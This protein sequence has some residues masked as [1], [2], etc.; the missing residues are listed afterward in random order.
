MAADEE[1][2]GR[3]V[4]CISCTPFAQKGSLPAGHCS[5]MEFGLLCV[6]PDYHG[7]GLATRLVSFIET[8]ARAAGGAVLQCELLVPRDFQKHPHP[9]KQMMLRKFYPRLGF[10]G[11]QQRRCSSS[12]SSSSRDKRA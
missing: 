2:A 8:A 1:A 12:S 6:A 7:G 3:V 9:F 4:G 11:A 10:T 5:I